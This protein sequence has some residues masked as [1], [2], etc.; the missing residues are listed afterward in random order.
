MNLKIYH[1]TDKPLTNDEAE[2]VTTFLHEHLDRYGD[3]RDH[4]RACVDYA[5]G[6]DRP[7][8][9]VIIAYDHSG[10]MVGATVI[11][12]T[13]MHGYIPDNILVYIAVRAD[14]R[15]QGVGAQL[16]QEAKQQTEGDIALHV[17]ADNPARHL[18]ERE[19]FTNPYLEMRWRR[20]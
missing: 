16:M 12:K 14:Q 13:G 17:E 6:V 8:G 20:S 15:G 1:S 10:T 2:Q 11:C 19:G 9:T 4:I 7:G 3:K 5:S 18:Y